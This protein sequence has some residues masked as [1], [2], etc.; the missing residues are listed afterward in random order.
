MNIKLQYT[1]K[2]VVLASLFAFLAVAV[3]CKKDDNNNPQPTATAK[4]AFLNG[5]FGSDS[6]DLFVDTKKANSKLLGFGDHLA[7]LS[8]TVGERAFEIKD[9]D[10]KSIAKKSFKTEKDNDYSILASNSADGKTFELIQIAD[11]L[12]APTGDKAKIRL[13]HLSPDAG[14]LNL[15]SGETVLAENISYK[16]A[17]L[18]KE[19]DAKKTSF[20]I[21]DADAEE[22]ILNVEGL[23]LAKGKIYTIW[24]SGL[25]DPEDQGEALKA[26]I[27][28]NK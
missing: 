21:V 1:S 22:T 23:D 17:S 25:Q 10:E 8:V 18:Y 3:G 20:E 2:S 9:K 26:R 7:Y 19:V 11:D 27:F 13:V 5:V 4:V 6:L 28:T 14:K 12:T 24:V 16:G 15:A